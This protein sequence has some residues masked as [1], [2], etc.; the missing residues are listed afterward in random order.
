MAKH[1]YYFKHDFNAHNDEKIVDLL[2]THGHEGYGI[3]WHL[4]ELLASADDYQLECN[5]KRLSFT[6]Q[7][8]TEILKSIIE[9]F[10]L[11]N[12]T[13]NNFWSDSLA[14]RMK[15]L[16]EIKEK[17]AEYGRK[18]GK[19]KAKAKQDLSK[20]EA[21]A[22]QIEAEERKGE[23]SIEEKSKE[24]LLL[25]RELAFY[26]SLK[27]FID[28]YPKDM[29]RAFY[30]YWREPN[31]SRSKMKWETEK[32]WDLSLRLSR[33]SNNNFNSPK[34]PQVN[35]NKDTPIYDPEQSNRDLEILK[36]TGQL[37]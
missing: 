4:I 30:D 25:A 6:M 3:F 11:F 35:P 34:Q 26:E 19:A 7:C 15:R 14:T 9:D 8:S 24:E 27:K 29:I 21:N 32:T 31:K 20:T 10:D 22:K 5:Y 12:I 23:E 37:R 18:G 13:E 16:D 33:W 28:Q 36:N 1:T 17:R 2:M